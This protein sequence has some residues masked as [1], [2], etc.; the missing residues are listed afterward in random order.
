MSGYPSRGWCDDSK[1]LSVTTDV[2]A[3]EEV[4]FGSRDKRDFGFPNFR[5]MYSQKPNFLGA[6]FFSKSFALFVLFGSKYRFSSSP[7]F[8]SKLW[9]DSPGSFS[10]GVFCMTTRKGPP[11]LMDTFSAF[12]L[13][14]LILE[15]SITGQQC[16]HAP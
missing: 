14:I 4:F 16:L 3:C 8:Y 13:Q 2:I 5:G 6:G 7:I 12:E 11:A 15:S 10:G 9:V 1:E